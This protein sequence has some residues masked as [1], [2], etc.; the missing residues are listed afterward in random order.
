MSAQVAKS[1]FQ[2]RVTYQAGE[3]PGQD[4]AWDAQAGEPG[5]GVGPVGLAGD[6]QERGD[7]VGLIDGPLVDDVV[8]ASADEGC[9]RHDHH[10]IADELRVLAAPARLADEDE[11][12]RG[13]PDRVADAVPVNWERADRERDGVRGDVDHVVPSVRAARRTRPRIT[14]YTGPR[15]T[16][17]HRPVS[18]AAQ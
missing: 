16:F 14:A 1:T 4:P 10:P 18:A 5:E 7:R 17:S 6:R 15:M 8:E 12:D 2:R 13:Q 9:D 11:V 3:R